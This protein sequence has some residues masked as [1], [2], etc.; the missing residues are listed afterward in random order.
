MMA[1]P[2]PS[3]NKS[4]FKNMKTDTD[5]KQDV[6]Q[7]LLWEPSLNAARI[8]VSVKNGVVELDG[9]VA[10]YYEKHAAEQAALRVADVRAIASEII[11]ELIP[12]ATR[13]DED[14][15]RMALNSLESNILVPD[16][17]K[18]QVNDGWLTLKGTAGWQYQKNQA[19]WTVGTMMGVK[20]ITNDIKLE[21]AVNPDGVKI[22]I[23]E[24]LKRSASVDASKIQVAAA[25]GLIT[26]TGNVS[27]RHEREEAERATWSAPGVHAVD[28]MITIG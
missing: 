7:E 18:V 20:G 27:S 3:I 15:A 17:V 12:S 24:A 10:S 25:G 26:L 1:T 22:K 19:Q 9:H 23:E 2:L 21:P 8:G 11:V 6:E 13:P 16:T 28:D 4:P 14:I 5:L